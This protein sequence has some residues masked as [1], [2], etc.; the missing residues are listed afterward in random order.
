MAAKGNVA[1]TRIALKT[2]NAQSTRRGTRYGT[3]GGCVFKP[4]RQLAGTQGETGTHAASVT[5]AK[6]AQVSFMTQRGIA[7]IAARVVTRRLSCAREDCRSD[8]KLAVRRAPENGLR[9]SRSTSRGFPRF[10]LT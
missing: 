7:A 2:T 5:M 1:E 3:S 4:I 10:L 8:L 6:A 9:Q